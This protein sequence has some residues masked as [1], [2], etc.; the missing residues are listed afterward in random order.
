MLQ[1][2]ENTSY[3][4]IVT[5]RE[6]TGRTCAFNIMVMAFYSL[7]TFPATK[8][9]ISPRQAAIDKATR[10]LVASESQPMTGGPT[11]KPKKLMLDTM[12]LAL[13]ALMVPSLPAML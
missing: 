11:K 4:S 2:D 13:L 10:R 9:I 5:V 3:Q 8:V 7:Q 6:L 12:V 1:N